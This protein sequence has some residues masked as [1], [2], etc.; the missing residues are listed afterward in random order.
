[1][2]SALCQKN[3]DED[4]DGRLI[5]FVADIHNWIKCQ[6]TKLESRKISSDQVTGQMAQDGSTV[7]VCALGCPLV[8]KGRRQRHDKSIKAV[9]GTL[10]TYFN[11]KFN[12][13]SNRTV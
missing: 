6:M 1:M 2:C 8:E 5:Q 10:G 3:L 9:G 11:L 4:F 12:M 13:T 7:V